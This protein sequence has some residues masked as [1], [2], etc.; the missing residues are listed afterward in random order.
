M[1]KLTLLGTIAGVAALAVPG[2][3]LASGSAHWDGNTCNYAKSTA[4]GGD[5]ATSV[6]VPGNEIY[7]Y[8][9][10]GSTGHA[11]TTAVGA[12]AHTTPTGG[13]EGGS[14]EAGAAL[15][16]GVVGPQGSAITGVPGAYAVVDGNDNNTAPP[17]GSPG[18]S[19]GYI[20]LSN[21]E[22]GTQ[23]PTC[24]GSVGSQAGGSIGSTNSGG[25]VGIKPLGVNAPVP[26][27]VC[28]NTSGSDWNGSSAGGAN[29]GDRDGCFI[30]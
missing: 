2:G 13:F 9:G 1:R 22:D 25:C 7:V 18:A 30:P 26:L 21:Y 8:E 29:D 10:N 12:C 28:G 19:Q 15:T 11:D 17:A 23:D 20:G 24:D 27:I 14:A 16:K 4:N 6:Q 5:Q 3:A